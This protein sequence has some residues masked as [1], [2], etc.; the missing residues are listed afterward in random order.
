MDFHKALQSAG[1][2]LTEE[3]ER[4]TITYSD[5]MSDI[6]Q[7]GKPIV[8][9]AAVL[10]KAKDRP[11]L[12]LLR[13]QRPRQ[14][15]E[16]PSVYTFK[17]TNYDLLLA[18]FNQVDPDRRG[19]FVDNILKLVKQGGRVIALNGR[20][21]FPSLMG[22][23]SDL[24]LI[25]E[26][27]VRTGYA[28]QLFAATNS[29]PT[30]TCGM[31]IMMMQIEETIALNFNL[32]TD[33]ELE[34]IPGWLT[35]LREMADSQTY[36]ARGT[37]GKMV[38]NP[39]YKSGKE[40]E[41]K[42]IV[43]AID[44]IVAECR[45]AQYFY[46]KGALQQTVNLEIESDKARVESFLKQLGF[47]DEMVQALNAAESDYRSNSTAFELKNCIGHLRSVLEFTHREAASAIAV[48]AGE[49][50]PSD[51]NA[52]VGYLKCKDFITPQQEKL[53]RGLWALLSDEGV[54]PI[55][56]KAEF[57][58]LLRNMVIEYS[59]LFLT[60]LDKKGIKIS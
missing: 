4:P 54:H 59:L 48:S 37:R 60:I 51:W 16:T 40:N 33:S 20:E 32:F 6:I 18:I 14:V 58:R 43:E 35:P 29:L 52:A 57:A 23:A 26:F 44:G 31:A 25:A 5:N 1:R 46:L 38:D 30:P 34:K 8:N 50:V 3:L 19:E 21:Y 13:K 27:C 9:I 53:V 24:P 15:M 45:Q 39:H 55:M 12:D 10:A 41:G 49:N 36:S 2:I 28:E 22:C 11:Y 56:A 47:R 42:G 7:P 17:G